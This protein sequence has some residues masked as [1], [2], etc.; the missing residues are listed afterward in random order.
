M[1][2][3]FWKVKVTGLK[4]SPTISFSVLAIETKS[5]NT[6]EKTSFDHGGILNHEWAMR[7][8]GSRCMGNYGGNLW[9]GRCLK[10]NILELTMKT[11]VDNL[12][13]VCLSLR[14]IQV[15]PYP[16]FIKMALNST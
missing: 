14:Y 12:R 6:T 4:N 5:G 13:S 16:L 8:D 2:I 10:Q 3:M 15:V 1:E 7:P 11:S 9:Q